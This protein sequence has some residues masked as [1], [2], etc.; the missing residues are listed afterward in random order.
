[1]IQ[2]SNRGPCLLPTD[3]LA[4]AAEATRV[5]AEQ[6]ITDLSCWQNITTSC[7]VAFTGAEGHVRTAV[8][9]LE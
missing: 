3:Y 6:V 5:A 8:K 1:M 2:S 4:V 9:A 7:A